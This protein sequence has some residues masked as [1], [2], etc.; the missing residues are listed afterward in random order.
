MTSLEDSQQQIYATS[1]TQDFETNKKMASKLTEI[2]MVHGQ[3]LANSLHYF[4][5]MLLFKNTTQE[6]SQS[7]LTIKD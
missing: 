3:D 1:E 7:I 4:E 2:S 6:N 5:A